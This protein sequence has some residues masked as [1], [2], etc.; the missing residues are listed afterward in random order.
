MEYRFFG[1][2]VIARII[3][4]FFSLLVLV[5]AISGNQNYVTSAVLLVLVITESLELTWF[6][7]RINRE[8]GHFIEA[9]RLKDYSM[10][11]YPERTGR[12]FKPLRKA[13][14]EVLT[15]LQEAREKQELQNLQLQILMDHLE[16]ALLLFD[17]EYRLKICNQAATNLFSRKPGMDFFQKNHK[18]LSK[19]IIE[20]EPG[21]KKLYELTS[22]GQRMLLSV[23]KAIF[24][25]KKEK[26]TIISLQDIHFELDAKEVDAWHKLIRVLTHEIMNSVTPLSSL[27]QAL[28]DEL[29]VIT[30][31]NL[32]SIL[33]DIQLSAETINSRSKDLMRFISEYKKLTKVEAPVFEKI[34]IS[35]LLHQLEKLFANELEKSG[36][37]MIINKEQGLSPIRAD[38]EMV[39]RVL[40]NLVRNAIQAA[41][42]IKEAE[43]NIEAG[44]HTNGI[45][46]KIKDNGEGIPSEILPE[47]F[48]PFFTTRKQGSG[49]GLSICRRIMQ[50]HA[51]SINV[52]SEPGKGTVFTLF[53]KRF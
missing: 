38:K 29:K 4:L 23:R 5:I 8:V 51:G 6:V 9:I 40:I 44:N 48:I 26:F 35:E 42:K 2:K 37:F 49:V 1:L 34:N 7:N 39:M 16:V 10:N 31:Q 24:I 53:F 15:D 19:F 21:E 32:S 47:I 12:S 27:S 28:L 50:L 45:L 30:S 3:I 41:R 13:L 20:A 11:Y 18:E 33:P 25:H 22:R 46:L 17:S 52:D 43:I 36:V 14:G